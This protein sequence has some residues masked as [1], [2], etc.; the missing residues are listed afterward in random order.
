MA[1]TLDWYSV[2][3]PTEG[4]DWQKLAILNK[5]GFKCA[6][7]PKEMAH[8]L[9]EAQGTGKYNRLGTG[10]MKGVNKA[11]GIDGWMEYNE[12]MWLALQALDHR[13]ILEIGSWKGR[14]TKVLAYYTKGTVTVVDSWKG[15]SNIEV[16]AGAFAD[17]IEHGS[18]YIFDIFKENIKDEITRIN[19]FRMTSAEAAKKVTGKFD[20][21]FIDGDHNY[22]PFKQDLLDYKELL[23]EGG[24]LCGHDYSYDGVK[25][26][27]KEVFDTKRINVLHNGNDLNLWW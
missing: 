27:L 20:M 13:R 14:S 24:L 10:K 17:L 3:H 22:E 11:L 12:L 18:D 15:S 9:P 4:A 2:N 1:A 5:Y 23:A 25:K 16:Y 26:A 7:T 8:H 21:I 19:I 6:V